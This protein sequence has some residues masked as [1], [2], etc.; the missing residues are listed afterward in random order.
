MQKYFPASTWVLQGWQNNPSSQILSKLDKSKTLVQELFGEN[1]SNW[2]TRKC[3]EGT[4]FIWCTVTNFGEKNGLCGK[5][6][7]FADEVHKANTSECASLMKGVGI[8]P[9]GL[10]NNPVV[11]DFVLDLAWHTEKVETT[12]WIK[13]FVIAR[14][15]KNNALLQQAWHGFLQTIY[16]SFD[17]YQEGPNE[18]VFCARPSLNVTS[19]SSWG[20]RARNYDV[21]KF[22][23]AVKLFVSVSDEM[24]N[25]TTYQIDKIDMVRQVLS[26]TGEDVYKNMIAAFEKKDIDLFTKESSTFLSLMKMQDSLLSGN[27]HFQLHT[28]LK[29]ATDFGKTAY[30]KKLA[31]KNAKTQI[32]YWGPNNPETELHEYANKEWSGLVKYYYL[33]RWEMFVSEC[34]E[35]LRGGSPAIPGYFKFEQDWSNKANLYPSIKISL[36]QQEKIIRRI[37]VR[38]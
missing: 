3:Y 32:T 4:P 31:L 28:W 21:E 37:L 16:S 17:K 34:K 10:H 23:D 8:M 33:P 27:K 11:Y 26:N 5:L 12:K 14:Y 36:M 35:K 13:S 2:L 25:S 19:V 18:S 9:E 7:R 29:Q 15:G 38:T 22:K 24:K 30:E 20:T 1:T 6:R